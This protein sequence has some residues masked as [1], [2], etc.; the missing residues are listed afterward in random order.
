MSI[1]TEKRGVSTAAGDSW[2]RLAQRGELALKRP[3]A[4]GVGHD[5]A[6]RET[7]RTRGVGEWNATGARPSSDPESPSRPC[8]NEAR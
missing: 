6:V 2:S 1:I 3:L 8:S 4:A 5:G 7:N